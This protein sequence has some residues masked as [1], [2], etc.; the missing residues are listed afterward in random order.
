MGHILI[1]GGN[2]FLGKQIALLADSKGIPVVSIARSGKPVNIPV[3]NVTWVAADIFE[4]ELWRA[5]LQDCDA[6]IHCIGILEEDESKGITHEK[7]I[8]ETARIVGNEAEHAG[9][10]KF[11]FISAGSGPPGTPDSYI[12]NKR[13]AEDYLTN[14]KF[15]LAILRPGMIYGA[16]KPES[17]R[18]EKVISLLLKIPFI[19]NK[20]KP[21][22][23]LPVAAVATASLYAAKKEE[24]KGILTVDDIDAIYKHNAEPFTDLFVP[25]TDK[26]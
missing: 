15:K 5:Q 25:F 6:V 2:G 9:I 10:K 1:T 12:D 8:F 17:M 11:V 3:N 21:G 24:V 4:P 20:L 22:R 14:R 26:A 23:P 7:M 18:I 19:K 16:E 13:K